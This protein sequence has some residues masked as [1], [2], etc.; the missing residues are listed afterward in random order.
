MKVLQ[1][2]H[3]PLFGS[4]DGGKIAMKSLA[5]SL[6]AVNVEVRQ[7][8]IETPSHPISEEPTAYP[9]TWKSTFIDTRVNWVHALANLFKSES[10]NLSRFNNQEYTELVL[11]EIEVFQPDFILA[12]GIYTIADLEGIRARTRVP[13][14]LRTHNVEFLIWERMAGSCSNPLKRAYLKLLAKRLKHAEIALCNRVDA[15]W[16]ISDQDASMWR[17]LGVKTPMAVIGIGIPNLDQFPLAGKIKRQ[18]VHLASMDWLPNR[19]GLDWFIGSIW[20]QVQREFPDLNLVLAGHHMPDAYSNLKSMR[21]EVKQ[22]ANARE[23]LQQEG[24]LIVPLK[25][26]SGIRVKI[27]EALAC[28]I[29]VITTTIGCEGIAVQDGREVLIADDA[30]SFCMKIKYLLSDSAHLDRISENAATFARENYRIED[31]GRKAIEFYREVIR[32]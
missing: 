3:K 28:G 9:F 15:I 23:F 11:K 14:V 30:E 29:P 21:I 25:S 17:E 1:L 22:A 24:I 5:D 8:M 4:P 32:P 20:P 6:A 2:C 7:C 10:Y 19:E 18:L 13:I 12:E 16:A 27:L 31:I 26:G